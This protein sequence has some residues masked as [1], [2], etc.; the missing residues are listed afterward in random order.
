MHHNIKKSKQPNQKCAENLNRYLSKNTYRWPKKHMKRCSI[1]LIIREM[2]IKT[3]VR[4][5]HTPIRMA[6]IK[7]ST[8]NK[9]QR[10]CEKK[11][12]LLHF[13]WECKLVEPLWR[14][15][16]R[17]QKKPKYTTNIRSSNPNPGYLCGENHN[18]KNT[19]TSMFIAALFTI[20]RI[21]KQPKCPSTEDQ[22]QWNI[23]EI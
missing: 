8:N 17:F 12:T 3:I 9:C 5:H 6:I 18:S 13:W 11:G 4:Y 23:T 14:M 22:R 1:L 2:Q 15:V 10:G 16:W 21:W 19:C 7:K 20:A